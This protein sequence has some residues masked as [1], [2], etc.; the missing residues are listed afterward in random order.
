MRGALPRT[1]C[2][3]PGGGRPAAPHRRRHRRRRRPSI[4]HAGCGERTR[5]CHGR[6]GHPGRPHRGEQSRGSERDATRSMPPPLSSSARAGWP[7]TVPWPR[8]R[9]PPITTRA[10]TPSSRS[11]RR[12]GRRCPDRMSCGTRRSQPGASPSPRDR[13]SHSH[14]R[15]AWQR[16]DSSAVSW[17]HATS[18]LRRARADLASDPRVGAQMGVRPAPACSK[19]LCHA[20]AGAAGRGADED[21][22]SRAGAGAYARSRAI[23]RQPAAA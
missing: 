11:A 19:L 14:D 9:L 6:R 21:I 17:P 18:V 5:P 2:L 15:A 8:P 7:R 22:V 4:R 3:A 10:S 1:A 13:R 12:A 16:R 23:A 20:R